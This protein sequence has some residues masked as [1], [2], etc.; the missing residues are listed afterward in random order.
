[1]PM[2]K[3]SKNLKMKLF[4]LLGNPNGKSSNSY[5]VMSTG[6]KEFFTGSAQSYLLNLLYSSS[7]DPRSFET[8]MEVSSGF[9]RFYKEKIEVENLKKIVE[10]VVFAI[11]ESNSGA[12]ISVLDKIYP[13]EEEAN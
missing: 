1:M 8:V 11:G 6:E 13:E 4:E 9:Y 3:M 5:R 7:I 2:D 10:S 12:N